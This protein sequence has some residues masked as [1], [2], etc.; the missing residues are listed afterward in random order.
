MKV[1]IVGNGNLAYHLAKR[2]F[3]TKHPIYVLSV[4]SV[5]KGEDFRPF[6]GKETVIT[7]ET[8]L[9]NLHLDL[10]II[11][12]T[13]SAIVD[14]ISTYKFP[15][16]ATIVHT[17]GTHSINLFEHSNT[18]NFGVLYPLQTFTKKKNID[19]SQIPVFIESN[20]KAAFRVIESLADRLSNKVSIL[21]TRERRKIHL[22]ATIACNF[23]NS[24]YR[25][26][27]TQLNVI[28]LDFELIKPLINETT[29]KAL[30]IGPSKSQTGPA[31]RG[32]E[33]TIAK[34][35]KLLKH[36]VE[37]QKIYKQLT[38]LIQKQTGQ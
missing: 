10:V 6:F 33:I 22:A 17:S 4:R 30:S 12:V 9:S 37:V 28:G 18:E 1:A 25:L 23:S 19:F 16:K 8:N 32:D 11:V 2:L 38:R 20:N 27:E 26:A 15:S 7:T 5:N 24:L 34:H 31:S 36:D 35:K 21:R 29:Q 3:E 14:I 13:D